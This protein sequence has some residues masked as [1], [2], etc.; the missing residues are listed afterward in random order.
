MLKRLKLRR[1]FR[2][3]RMEAELDEELRYHLESVAERLIASGMDPQEARREALRGFGGFEQKK[4]ECRD[5]VGT[6]LIEDLW[7]DLR[8]GVRMMRKA[9]AFTTIAVVTLTLGIG[10]NA[11]IFSIVNAVLLR[12]LPYKDPQRLVMVFAPDGHYQDVPLGSAGFLELRNQNQSFQGVAAFFMHSVNLTG[13]GEPEFLGGT[14]ASSNLF[15]L[16]GIEPRYGRTFLQ[17]EE[18]PGNNRVVI[19]SH[20]LWQRR[21]GSDQK[22]IGQSISLNDEPHTIVGVMPPGFQFPRKGDLW[23]AWFASEIDIYVPLALTPEQI[24]NRKTLPI[25]VIA[26]LKP[27]FSIEQARAEMNGFAAR[28]QERYPSSDGN[29]SIRLV[30][31]Q[32]SVVERARFALLVLLGA[33]GFVLLIACTNVANLLL[34]RAAARQKEIAIRAALGAG[35][36]RVIRQLL[37][38]SM[39]LAVLSGSL[40][41]L[42]AYCGVVLLKTIIPEYLPR[43]DEI[44]VDVWVFGFTLLISMLT[45]ILFGAV[46]AFQASKLRLTDSL[47][48]GNRVSGEGSHNR[49]RNLLVVSEVALALVLLVGAGLILRSFIRLMNI[50]PGLNPHNALTVDIT[51]PATKY[52]HT[53]QAAFFHHVLARLRSIPGIQAAGAVYPLPLSTM[54]ESMGFDIEGQPP[55]THGED[56]SAGPRGVGPDYFKAQGIP[57]LKGRDFR[58]TDGI[59]SPP[60]VVINEV[61]ARRYWPNQDPV[62]RRIIFP[63][64]GRPVSWEIIGV[65]GSVRHMS[66]DVDLRPEIYVPYAQYP[67]AFMTLVIRTD[68]DPLKFVESVRKQ[69][70]AVDKDQPISNI[71]TMDALLARTVS[72]PRFNLILLAIFATLAL[73]LAAVGIYGVMSYIVTQRTHEIGVRMALGA[74]TRD[75]IKLVVSQCLALILTGVAIGLLAAFG[76]TRLIKNLLFGIGATDPLTFSLIAIILIG[77]ALL[78][79]YLPARRATKVDPIVALRQE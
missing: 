61:M 21:F 19:I 33:V 45:G 15:T 41:L 32:Q 69:I 6:R 66:L 25:A 12:P 29:R 35:R 31:L 27:Q 11:A 74:Q 53:Q 18:R 78:A 38:E 55:S 16:L 13:R 10:A 70:Q 76:L 51:L 79:C 17:D 23:S 39:L 67:L 63:Y 36:R 46:P 20:R 54:E 42:L 52:D 49:L 8:Y 30:T 22:I 59:G 1:L 57:L 73:L 64:R 43:A 44:G 77:V 37:T 62:A 34:V 3:R 9:P 65:V 47:K 7:G 68:S 14:L 40:A 26:R 75:V 58:E 48:E 28:L 2:M 56:H 71:N 4:E 24:S 60:V 5:A 50:D 72:Q